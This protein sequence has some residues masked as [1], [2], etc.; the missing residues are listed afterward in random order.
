MSLSWGS[1]I[2][3]KNNESFLEKAPEDVVEKVKTIQRGL[4][5]KNDKLKENLERI[6]T[7]SG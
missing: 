7:I 1:L 4:E 3:T 5:E 2:L 6:K